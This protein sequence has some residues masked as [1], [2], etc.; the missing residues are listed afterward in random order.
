MTSYDNGW[1]CA[2]EDEKSGGWGNGN[3]KSSAQGRRGMLTRSIYLSV[4]AQCSHEFH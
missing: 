1:G 4:C 2:G 3:H